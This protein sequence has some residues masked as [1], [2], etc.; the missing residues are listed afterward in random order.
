MNMYDLL[1]STL[2]ALA[3][4]PALPRVD[5]S[6]VQG[7]Y[8]LTAELPGLS[9]EQVTVQVTDGL[10]EVSAPALERSTPEGSRWLVRERQNQAFHRS[11]RLPR[12]VDATGIEAHFANGLLKLI[13]PKKPEAQPRTVAIK[14]AA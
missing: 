12:D 2:P 6:E 1:T 11:F 5:V 4:V 7:A 10:L 13:L 9:P 3:S 14:T 8:E